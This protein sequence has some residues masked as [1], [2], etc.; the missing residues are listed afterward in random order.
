MKLKILF[1]I[2]IVMSW[3]PTS[4]MSAAEIDCH[5]VS[6][7]PKASLDGTFKILAQATNLTGPSVLVGQGSDVPALLWTL[8]PDKYAINMRLKNNILFDDRGNHVVLNIPYS[9]D[10]GV[11]GPAFT[12]DF[13]K[14]TLKF[15]SVIRCNE[16]GQAFQTLRLDAATKQDFH[17]ETLWTASLE[18][19]SQILAADRQVDG[20]EEISLTLIVSWK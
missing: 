19:D 9:E 8:E 15:E 5:G 2:T 20:P 3:S 12:T 16:A 6:D 13:I 17:I 10:G 14:P 18:T 7:P 11:A 4:A 1:L